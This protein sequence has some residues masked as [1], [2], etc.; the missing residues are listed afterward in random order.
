MSLLLR[1]VLLKDTQR[2]GSLIHF[3]MRLNSGG[4]TFGNPIEYAPT[5]DIYSYFQRRPIDGING[6]NAA[7]R[8][9]NYQMVKDLGGRP[10][11][12]LFN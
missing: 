10:R 6:S 7:G 9:L 4:H 3:L 12:K 1:D 5:G 8:I 11:N 2:H